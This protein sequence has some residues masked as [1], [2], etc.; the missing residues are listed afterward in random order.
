MDIIKRLTELSKNLY[1][2]WHPECVKVFRDINTE[3]W[4]DVNH[5]PVDFLNR[6]ANDILE[7]KFQNKYKL[8]QL[9]ER[10]N[11][12]HEYLESSEI[13]GAW[14]AGPLRA[15]PVAY[16]SAEFA[17]HESLPIYSGGLGALAGDHLKAASDLGV[18][19]V[20]IGLSY[21]HGYFVQSLDFEGWQQEHYFNVSDNILPIELAKNEFGQPL[22]VC[23][24]TESYQIWVGIWLVHVGRNLLIL[25]DTNV[26]GN[27]SD[28][29]NLTSRLY[30]GDKHIRLLQELI[31]GVGGMLALEALGITPSVIHLNEGH[32]AFACL[33]FLRML[34]DRDGQSFDNM[35]EIAASQIVFT[36]HTAVAAGHDEFDP[37]LLVKVLNPLITQLGISENRLLGLGRVDPEDEKENF[38][39]TVLAMKMSRYRNAVSF[40]HCR[41]TRAIWNKLWPTTSQYDVPINYITN[42]VHISTWLAEPMAKLYNKYLGPKWKA[43]IDDPESWTSMES[44]DDI[45]LWEKNSQLRAHLVDYIDRTVQKQEKARAEGKESETANEYARQA[46]LNPAVLTI[47]IARRFARY[48]RMDLLFKDPARLE[49]LV[50]NSE[51]PVQFIFAGKA[52]P[53]DTDAKHVIQMVFRF[54]RDPRFIGKIVFIENYDINVCRHLVQGVDAWINVPRRPLEACGTSGQKVAMNG[55]LNISVLDGWW[56]QAYDGANGFAIGKGSE[57]S[58]L[59]HQDYVDAEALYDV[60]ENEVVP[61]FYNRNED[62]I[63]HG[64][65]ARQKHALRTLTWRFSAQRMV[66]DYTLSCYLPAAGGL[67]SSVTADVRL[68]KEAFKL[69]DF[70]RQPW[71]EEVKSKNV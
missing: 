46:K 4:R 18:P 29:K 59:D 25:L 5:N 52:H 20:G 66:M 47:G 60:L 31:L 57:H 38:S 28:D 7:D 33:E 8:K 55:G 50:N 17:L 65:V 36:T 34:M 10:L 15:Q 22:R 49:R 3:L 14:Q 53:Q 23:V 21:S 26:E 54:T 30:G 61:L 43:A 19:I 45:E 44:I 64:W 67:T 70:A 39:M 2:A 35:F 6:L 48:K 63:P 58:N 11:D 1:W 13:W 71:I 40:L 62:G 16:F 56:A 27:S 12:L 69:P 9:T 68:L 24:R 42:G 37:E 51:R 41:L 32:S